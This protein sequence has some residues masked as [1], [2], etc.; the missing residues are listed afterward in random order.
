MKGQLFTLLGQGFPSYFVLLKAGFVLATVIG[1]LWA[2]RVGQNPDVVVDLGLAMVIAGVAGARILHVL[3]D[4][5]DNA[6]IRVPAGRPVT[7]RITSADVTHG[8]QIVGTNGNTM[9]VPGYVSQFTVTF[10][11]PGTYHIACNEYCGIGHHMMV[12]TF[13][14]K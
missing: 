12:G 13:T 8:F 1:A 7:F 5:F 10:E 14:V 4:G 6:E 11:T 2:R 9:V 3:A